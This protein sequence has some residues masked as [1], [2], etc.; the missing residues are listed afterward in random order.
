MV[1]LFVWNNEGVNK[2][3]NI[4]NFNFK[5]II[6]MVGRVKGK[7]YV[8]QEVEITSSGNIEVFLQF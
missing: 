6:K 1:E 3:W 7:L 4:S 2:W 5:K 8:Y